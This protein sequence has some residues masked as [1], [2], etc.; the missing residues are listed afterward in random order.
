MYPNEAVTVFNEFTSTG[1]KELLATSTRTI[2]NI[3]ITNSTTSPASSIVYCGSVSTSNRL[4]DISLVPLNFD[5]NN[6]VV[7]TARLYSVSTAG[8]KIYVTYVPYDMNSVSTTEMNY[9]GP[10]FHE[11]LL[12]A[13]VII[14]LL[15]FMSWKRM[16]IIAT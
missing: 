13:G 10:T 11:W 5:I 14:F 2:L 1:G 3:K 7:C 6:Q 15:S 9:T 16:S 12:V 4:V 8:T